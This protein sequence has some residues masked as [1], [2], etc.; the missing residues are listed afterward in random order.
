MIAMKVQKLHI[1]LVALVLSVSAFAQ[2]SYKQPPKEVMDVLN[3]PAIPAISV[4][5]TRDKLALL[6]PLRY[7]PI[8]EVAQPM[9][10]LAG[11]R[12]NPNTNGQH[13]QPYFVKLTLKNISDGRET[14]V[15][16]PPDAKIISPQWSPN[17]KYLALGNITP[18]GIELWFVDTA[19]GK[20]QKVKNV[21]VNTAFGGI[22][23]I[24]SGSLLANLV[25]AKRGNAPAYQNLTPTE[26]NVQETRGRT[27]AVQTFQDLLKSPN[28]E[29]L[30]EYYATSQLAIVGIDGKVKEIGKPA[31]FDDAAVSPNGKYILTTRIEKPFSYQYPASRFPKQVEVVDLSQGK[32][33]KV[34]SIPLQ[35]NLPVQG[36]PV[37]PRSISWIPTEPA[38]LIWA[39]ALDGGDPRKKVTPRDRL[40]ISAAPFAGEPKEI[41]KIEQR[42]QGRQFGEKDGL[43]LFYDYNRDTEHRRM[44]MTDYRN[45]SNV[46]LVSDLNVNDRYNDIG[47]PITKVLPDGGNVIRQNGDEIFLTGTGASPD[48]DRPFFR[49]MN[50]KT[51]KTDEIFRS[52]TDQYESFLGMIDDNGMQFLTRKESVTEPPNV[53]VRQVCPPEQV[54]TQMAYRQVTDFKDPAPQLRGITKKLVKYKRADGVDLSFTLYLPPGY[55][56]GT[57]LPTV[58][59]AYPLEFTDAA[60]AGQVSGSTNRFTQISG[61]SHLFFLLEGYAV[62]DDTT[63]PIVGD[64]LTVNDTFVQ[65]IVDSAKA[66]I[67]KGV[68][69]GVVDPDRVGVGGH[70]YGAFMTGNLLAHSRL[71]RAGIAR[72][73]AY[74]RTLTPF[75]FQSERRTFWEAPELYEKVSPFFYADKIKDPILLIHGEADNNQGTFPMQS[76]RLFAAISGTGGTARLVM[77]P[78][79]AHGY[80]AKESTEH[81]LYEMINWFDKYVKNAKPREQKQ[82]AAQ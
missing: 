64:P 14:P 27:G 78:M 23:W 4:S 41:V 47:F 67:D 75:G 36:V 11:L 53:F 68:E 28:D 80:A 62:L 60:T 10:R 63:M 30:F 58:V 7:P 43:M 65:Q 12:I 72:S 82:V 49:R 44:F 40:M 51:L 22:D 39:E 13:R 76:E 18:T 66:A 59:W 46:K 74:N 81:V 34:A 70:S 19:T 15:T 55:K 37:G 33:Y 61:Y 21:F 73:G 71:F 9:L 17:G 35:D 32:A 42:Y 79:E 52:G 3:A 6:Q 2:G 29:R 56:E 38:M 50:L 5:P 45:P 8:S 69:L 31:I 1:L 48:G 26:P 16:L 54:C 24:D 25:P 77:L 57:R 20:A